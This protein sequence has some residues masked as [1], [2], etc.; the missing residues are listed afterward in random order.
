MS[1]TQQPPQPQPQ[2]KADRIRKLFD[3]GYSIKE[4]A[5]KVSTH[6]SYAHAVITRHKNENEN[7]NKNKNG[8]E[9]QVEERHTK[10]ANIRVLHEAG[11]TT[12]EIVAQLEVTH[13]H[14]SNVLRVH[15]R[16]E[17]T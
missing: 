9:S 10:A 8:N 2:T 7:E 6:Y 15:K 16:K 17:R 11:Y 4:V 14:V 12:P 13:S 5:Q 3:D 1:N